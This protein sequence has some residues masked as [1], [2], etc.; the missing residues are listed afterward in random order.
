MSVGVELAAEAQDHSGQQQT[1]DPCQHQKSSPAGHRGSQT[2]LGTMW[3]QQLLMNAKLFL[4]LF[5]ITPQCGRIAG[6]QQPPADA[7]ARFNQVGSLQILQIH[8]HP[9]ADQRKTGTAIRFGDQHATHSQAQAPDFDL[10]PNLG[11]EKRQQTL[12]DP[13]LAGPRC[14]RHLFAARTQRRRQ[15]PALRP[16]ARRARDSDRRPP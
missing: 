14:L 3:L 9:G 5:P 10:I 2:L 7:T 16:A 12:I 13:Y 1:N 8:Q 6:Q 15:M 4:N 11:V